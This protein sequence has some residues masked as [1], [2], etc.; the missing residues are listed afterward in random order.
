MSPAFEEPET[1]KLHASAGVLKEI[2]K[3]LDTCWFSPALAISALA[4]SPMIQNF[5]GI[6]EAFGLTGSLYVLFALSSAIF[7]YRGYPFLRGSEK[8]DLSH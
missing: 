3:G 1:T 7:F 2:I 4:F 8:C 5:L 6:A